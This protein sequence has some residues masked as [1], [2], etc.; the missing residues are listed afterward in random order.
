MM[1]YSSDDLAA[2]DAFNRA[3]GEPDEATAARM[4]AAFADGHTD[5]ILMVVHYGEAA[6]AE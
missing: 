6:P 1:W 3:F 5:Q 4:E 2:R